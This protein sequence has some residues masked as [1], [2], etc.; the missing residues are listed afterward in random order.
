MRG[1]LV[2]IAVFIAVLIGQ[3][4]EFAE[5]Y[6]LRLGCA[7]EG[8]ERIV[9]HFDEDSRRSGYDRQGALALMAIIPSS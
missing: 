9:G 3:A 7:I 8:L 6:A 2:A 5:Q 4:P 1:L